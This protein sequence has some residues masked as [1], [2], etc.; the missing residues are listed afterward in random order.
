[1]A[2]WHLS[3]MTS[4]AGRQLKSIAS[5]LVQAA[6]KARRRGR[7]KDW[8]RLRTTSRRLR[9]ALTA[10][11][12]TL[13]PAPR[14]ALDRRAKKITK[15][16]AQV[17][18]LDVALDN[19]KALRRAAENRPERKAAKEMSRRLARKRD[20]NERSARRHLARKR[21]VQRLAS[22]LKKALRQ[23]ATPRPGDSHDALG[24]AARLVLERR[25]AVAGWEDVE[26]LHEL[27]VAVKKYRGALTAWME[28]HPGHVRE[29]RATLDGLQGLQT[30]LGEHHDWS[31]L[32]RRLDKR[33]LALATDGAGHRELVGY[34]ALLDRARHEQKARYEAYL[35]LQHDRLPR[36]LGAG[37]DPA[38]VA[39]PSAPHKRAAETAASVN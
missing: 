35:A 39:V 37:A 10:F 33:R 12:P 22:Q 36:W 38:P 1:L 16:P 9:G 21:P 11:A 14:T 17:R 8:H 27:R 29:N 7:P 26:T 25:N 20:R 19:L 23:S 6:R 13:A 30:V 4:E 18:D 28:A 3:L 5:E 31:E 15:L 2:V 32:A 34:E 24:A